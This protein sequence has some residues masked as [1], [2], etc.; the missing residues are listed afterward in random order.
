MI[1]IVTNSIVLISYSLAMDRLA[2]FFEGF[3]LTAQVFY[4]G[5]LCGSTGNNESEQ[6]GHLHVLRKGRLKITQ[7]NARQ[8]VIAT[9]S[10]L[11][12]PRPHRHRLYASEQEGA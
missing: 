6:A 7:A 8:M 2:P 12:F 3:P 10:I 5:L 1:R 11:F 9:P 4:S